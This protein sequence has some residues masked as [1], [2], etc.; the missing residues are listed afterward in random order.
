MGQLQ[1]LLRFYTLV[2]AKDKVTHCASRVLTELVQTHTQI[3]CFNN[4]FPK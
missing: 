1:E 3:N 4:H 2:L